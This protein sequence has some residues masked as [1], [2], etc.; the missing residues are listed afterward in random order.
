MIEPDW[1]RIGRQLEGESY[2]LDW[3]TNF[4][5]KTAGIAIKMGM[6]LLYVQWPIDY[7]DKWVIK[8]HMRR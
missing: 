6:T 4:T 3:L 5:P 1:G 8:S 7:T 2:V